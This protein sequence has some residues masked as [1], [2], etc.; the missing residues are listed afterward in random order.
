MCDPILQNP[1]QVTRHVFE[2][3]SHKRWLD[4][5]YVQIFKYVLSCLLSGEQ[6]ILSNA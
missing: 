4:Q 5:N 3:N 6:C 2:Y 1:E